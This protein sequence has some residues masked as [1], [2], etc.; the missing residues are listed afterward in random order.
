[1]QIV[2]N[3]KT[4]LEFQPTPDLLKF[5]KNPR[6]NLEVI[7]IID[8]EEESTSPPPPAPPAQE[9]P[10]PEPPVVD[11]SLAPGEVPAPNA[12]WVSF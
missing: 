12:E 9:P 5:A 4:G 3:I 10:A 11:S 2:R 1:M 7:E 8:P 6:N